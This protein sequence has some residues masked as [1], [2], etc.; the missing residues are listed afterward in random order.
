MALA[1]RA[2]FVFLSR[3]VRTSWG[4]NTSPV[5][6]FAN[7]LLHILKSESPTHLAAAFDSEGPT[8]RHKEY[9]AYKATRQQIPEDLAQAL[10]LIFELLDAF[11]VPIL[12]Y[13]GFEADDILGTLARRAEAEGFWVY[14]VS[15]DKDLAQL[16]S[17]RIFWYRPS[18]M[19]EAAETWGVQEVCRR[20]NISRPQELVDLLA[21][22]GDSSDNIPG[23]PGIGEK[24]ASLLISRFHTLENLLSH[25]SELEPKWRQRLEEHR[26]AALL[27]KRLVTIRCDL[28][29]QVDWKD[30]EVREPDRERL[31]ELFARLEFHT[32]ARRVFGEEGPRPAPPAQLEL[33]IPVPE[34]GGSSAQVLIGWNPEACRLVKNQGDLLRLL[35]RAKER[36]ALAIEGEASSLD[37]KT[38]ELLGLGLACERGE[39]WYLPLPLGSLKIE[40]LWEQLRSALAD[41]R[42]EKIGHDLKFLLSV[43]R[44]HGCEVEGPLFDTLLAHYVLEPEGRHD[45]EILASTFLGVS[46][47]GSVGEPDR[48]LEAQVRRAGQRV[49]LL[50]ELK[51][52]LENEI[53]R[54]K[55][56]RVFYEI[57]SPLVPVLVSMEVAGVTVDV[58]ALEDYGERL[59]SEIARIAQEIYELA[60][61]PF[62]LNSPKQLGEVL[63][64]R[65]GLEGSGKKTRT[66]Q[67]A[68][69]EAELVKL[70]S[71]YPI[72]KKILEYRALVKLKNTYVDALPSWIFP[73]TGR[74]HSTF[75]QAVTSTGRL[76]CEN[77]NLQNIPIRTEEGKEIRKAFIPRGPGYLLLSADYSQ[78][79][80]RIMAALSGDPGLRE[81]FET[82]MDIHRATASRVFGIPPETVTPEMRRTAKMVNFGIM[83]GIS[84]FGLAQR[85][86][87]SKAEAAEIINQYFNQYPGVRSYIERTIEFCREHGYVETVT[88]RRRYLP[89]IR[90]ANQTIRHAAERNAINAPIQGTAADLI[91]IAMIRL[92]RWL[93]GRQARTQLILQVHDELLFDLWEEEKQEVLPVVEQEMRGAL[94]LGIPIEVR[95]GLGKNWLEAGE[96]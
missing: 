28:P 92:Y 35:E 95:L 27:S 80:L 29:L 60:G 11:R 3:P 33:G 56:D 36:G 30:L 41:P 8:V 48:S 37:P 85:L 19:G 9:E 81:A 66:G 78:I 25:L 96:T 74:I 54:R 20:W 77:P 31:K 75:N 68:T 71:R 44:W 6:G 38:A 83:Y 87:I 89:D 64:E 15:P 32:L 2:Y 76:Q 63:F 59:Q 69:G 49:Q 62:N 14:L 10:P 61:L 43:F 82:G 13:P 5:F 94:S 58:K 67:Y 79:E 17:E 91:K 26:E 73:K 16:V 90:S 24:T 12:R 57:E 4:F 23:V 84:P 53:V 86:G 21:L 45:W 51:G 52:V 93:K 7:T 88:G 39:A 46:V 65:L 1:Y 47:E 50:W 72:A 70:A 42:V 18:R 22:V 40:D 34:G 55:Q